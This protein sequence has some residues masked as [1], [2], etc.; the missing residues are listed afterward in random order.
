LGSV[1]VVGAG[2]AGL[3]AATFAAGRSRSVCVID[4]TA[5]GGRKILISGGGR[6]NILPR[7]LQPD[8]FVSESSRALIRRMLRSWPIHEQQTF[9]EEDVGVPIALE[10]Q[11]GKYFP[12]SNRARDVRDGLVRLAKTRGVEFRF[13]T[14]LVNLERTPAGWLAETTTGMI[15]AST[16]IVATGGRSVPATGS[17]GAGLDL[18][19]KLG[20]TVRPTYPALTPLVCAPPRHAGLSGISLTVRLRARWR[21]RETETRGGLLFTHRGYSG[22]AVLDISH[23]AVRSRLA[24]GELARIRVRW[25]DLDAAAWTPFLASA[26]SRVAT[27]VARRIPAR[28]AA[29]LV[30]EA[31]IPASRTA[32]DLRRA[33][34]AALIERL[35][36]YE[37]PWSGDEGYQKAE[38]TGGG[39]ALE[40]IDPRTMESRIA[41]GLFLCGEILDAFG[42][43]GG[44][45]FAWAWATGRLAGLGATS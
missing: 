28:L 26:T 39:V 37:L 44:H 33:E 8:R 41:P 36:S 24:G 31:G 6:C 3:A 15:D 19:A 5:D 10:S 12:V 40:E 21:G 42:P 17:D 43:I 1:L 27:A 29:Q 14:R 7:E 13:G 16:V 30:A 11:T 9:F 25:T 45:N 35:T 2:A 4:T 34:R 18:A 20:H 22:P 23:V 38:V 32:A